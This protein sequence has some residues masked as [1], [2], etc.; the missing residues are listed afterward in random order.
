MCENELKEFK[1]LDIGD[2]L[3]YDIERSIL[4]VEIKEFLEENNIKYCNNRYIFDMYDFIF[5]VNYCEIIMK[6]DVGLAR[7]IYYIKGEGIKIDIKAIYKKDDLYDFL[8]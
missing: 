4:S 3:G 7:K 6:G 5:G 1:H 2:I 8:R